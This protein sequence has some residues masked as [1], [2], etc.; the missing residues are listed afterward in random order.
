MDVTDTHT[1]GQRENTLPPKHSC[2]FFF[3]WGGGGGGGGI[4]NVKRIILFSLSLLKTLCCNSWLIPH[5]ICFDQ[6]YKITAIFALYL[7]A[8]IDKIIQKQI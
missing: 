1:H 7:I 8:T 4:I 3:S 5:N 6:K 2:C